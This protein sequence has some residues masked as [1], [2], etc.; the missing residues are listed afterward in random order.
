M[1]EAAILSTCNR[2]E[3]Y[4]ASSEPQRA[5]EGIVETLARLDGAAPDEVKPYLA[6]M[7]GEPVVRHLCA[8]AA[9]LDSMVLGEPQVLGQVTAAYEEALACSAAGP[10]LAAL[11][12]QAIH[13]GKRARTETAIGER[14]ASV[15]HAAVELAKQI[16]GSLG[17]RRVLLIGAG[18]MAELAAKNL[19]DN[20][21][22]RI[23][24]LNRSLERAQTLASQ[25]H[26]EAFGWEALG[27]A[28]CQADIVI[29]SAAAPH[30]VI[31]ADAVR[32]AMTVRHGQPLFLIDIAVPRNVDAEVGRLANVYLY[33]I[34]DLKGVVQE[35]LEQRQRE[36]PKVE[37]IVAACTADY[38]AWLRSLDVA[39]TIRDLHSAA[40]RLCDAELSRALRKLGPIDAHQERVVRMLAH[41]IVSKLL[42]TPTVRLKEL[43][44]AGDG[45]RSAVA[46]RELFGLT[47]NKG[48]GQHA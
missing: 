44:D 27:R 39:S 17:E 2:F 7:H 6:A 16:F 30:S 14:A 15:S 46:L 48:E 45:Y 12:R 29:C 32:A 42:H 31:H 33:D 20:G 18:E 34:D 11:F 25:F 24:V 35:N 3:V 22:G 23:L 8:V 37:A 19:V 21:A 41:N 13:C 26:G 5:A 43:A 40:E 28:L 4:G 38:M 36:V 9:G 47:G 10:V 1:A